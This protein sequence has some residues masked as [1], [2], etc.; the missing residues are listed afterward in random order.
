ML[1]VRAAVAAVLIIV[2]AM[3]PLF[4][5]GAA[6]LGSGTAAYAAPAEG[7]SLQNGN[8]N[9]NTNKNGNNN[10][11][12]N[13]NDDDHDDNDNGNEVDD[14]DDRPPSTAPA[15][16][17][18]AARPAAPACSTPGQE[19]SVTSDDG[20]ITVR[21]FGSM[22]RPVRLAIRL[23]IEAGVTPAPP[24]P[25]V[26]GLLFQVIAEECGGGPIPVLPAEVNLGVRYSDA[27]AAGLNEQNFTIAR[28]DTNTNQWRTVEK[29]VAEPAG[30]Y[31]SA[32]ITDMGYYVV[33]QRS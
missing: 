33:Y 20:R 27:D 5:F 9:G 23:P 22:T 2:V 17:A 6:E 24:G 8:N 13:D 32:T 29:Q 12:A 25:L 15:A 1:L 7:P 18:S 21:V 28:L 10:G 30:N 4:G 19:S 31:D 3:A 16:P 26:G 11:N 14:G